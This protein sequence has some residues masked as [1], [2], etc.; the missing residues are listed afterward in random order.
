MD[1]LKQYFDALPGTWRI[2]VDT[3]GDLEIGTS[4]EI[5]LRACDQCVIPY[6]PNRADH[7]RVVMAITVR[8]A[9]PHDTA[10]NHVPRN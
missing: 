5:A 7:R 9:R 3:D 10:A 6:I 4:T 8:V 2:F 1:T